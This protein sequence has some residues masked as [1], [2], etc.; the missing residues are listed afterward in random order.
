MYI[1]LHCYLHQDM[2]VPLA[3]EALTA[4]GLLWKLQIVLPHFCISAFGESGRAQ[5]IMGVEVF[6][7]FFGHGSFS[8]F[9]NRVATRTFLLHRLPTCIKTSSCQWRT[10]DHVGLTFSRWRMTLLINR[11]IILIYKMMFQWNVSTI[12]FLNQL[13]YCSSLWFK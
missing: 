3:A 5:C 6:V 8:V 2:P 9:Y 10:L 13:L 1:I 7:L 11:T 4:V 12:Y